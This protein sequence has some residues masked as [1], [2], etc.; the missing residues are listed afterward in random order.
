[1]HKNSL[2]EYL[3]S[4]SL[5][6]S[7]FSLGTGNGIFFK[8]TD[9]KLDAYY[10]CELPVRQLRLS[11]DEQMIFR[12]KEQHI[13]IYSYEDNRNP[14]TSPYHF[15][16]TIEGQDKRVHKLHVYF[17]HQDQVII[18]PRM[19]GEEC[20]LLHADLLTEFAIREARKTISAL[21]EHRRQAVQRLVTDYRTQSEKFRLSYHAAKLILN[22]ESAQILDA[23][24]YTL[25]QLYLLDSSN[26]Y[27]GIRD[28]FSRVKTQGHQQEVAPRA[29]LER[30]DEKNPSAAPLELEKSPPKNQTPKKVPVNL[31]REIANLRQLFLDYESEQAIGKKTDLFIQFSKQLA[32]LDILVLE[33]SR[34]DEIG[35]ID[36]FH[37]KSEVIGE[38]I[39]LSLLLVE[40][41]Y[42]KAV[43][44][45]QYLGENHEKIFIMAL[46]SGNYELLEFILMQHA[47][48]INT[49]L[50]Q[51][52]TAICFCLEHGYA[53]QN[54]QIKCLGLLI[55]HHAS[56]LVPASDGLPVAYH[57]HKGFKNP[58]R[59]ILLDNFEATL[60][61]PGYLRNLIEQMEEQVRQ[62][63]RSATG[64]SSEP[65]NALTLYRQMLQNPLEL[66]PQRQAQA[67]RELAPVLESISKC[68]DQFDLQRLHVDPDF[69]AGLDENSR[70]LREL[71]PLLN[72]VEK[73]RIQREQVDRLK[74]IEAFIS[75]FDLMAL[76]SFETLKTGS[77][78]F[79]KKAN[80]S[81]V[82]LLELKTVQKSQKG[83]VCKT[84]HAANATVPRQQQL[85]QRLAQLDKEMYL[86]LTLTKVNSSTLTNVHSS[87]DAIIESCNQLIRLMDD[88]VHTG[89]LLTDVDTLGHSDEE[90]PESDGE[91]HTHTPN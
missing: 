36:E 12:V 39:V 48:P 76:V 86:P 75:Q 64:G 83:R 7:Q 45:T 49:V 71:M 41:D 87:I 24:I 16:A 19:N 90:A 59:Q 69:V 46:R 2:Y 78:E 8:K 80:E 26:H 51:D 53:D 88:L 18:A 44:L 38:K 22:E 34:D 52:K 61:K 10:L 50:I 11:L 56:T 47:I 70:L 55:K 40:R 77:I 6:Q 84:A 29:L 43:Q 31:N 25:G 91:R 13:T 82:C 73:T 28:H 62:L 5:S 89:M 20:S 21:R 35:I 33:S 1:M 37:Y 54:K 81:L 60:G 17:N 63:G 4:A 68:F 58:L 74:K 66:A 15:T 65:E 9:A 85:I 42:T 67:V 79:L 23:V 72:G 32:E 30:A 3:K 14:H 57:L 27:R